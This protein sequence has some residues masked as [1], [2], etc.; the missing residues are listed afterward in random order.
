MERERGEGRGRDHRQWRVAGGHAILRSDAETL[1]RP[2]RTRASSNTPPVAL[3]QSVLYNVHW[4][5]PVKPQR[6]RNGGRRVFSMG[7]KE[8][9]KRTTSS[10]STPSSCPVFPSPRWSIHTH[11]RTRTH[12]R[13][14]TNVAMS[15]TE[16]PRAEKGARAVAV[17]QG[18]Y[19]ARRLFALGK[20]QTDGLRYEGL[21]KR[22]LSFLPAPDKVRLLP[23]REECEREREW[24]RR[25][26]K[27]KHRQRSC[28]V[29]VIFF[30]LT[31]LL[32]CSPFPCVPSFLSALSS[33]LLSGPPLPPSPPHCLFPPSTPFSRPLAPL[34]AAH[35]CPARPHSTPPNSPLLFSPRSTHAERDAGRGRGAAVDQRRAGGG[36]HAHCRAAQLRARH[37]LSP[38]HGHVHCRAGP[39]QGR[40]GERACPLCRSR[41]QS[42]LCP[43]KR[44]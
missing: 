43:W 7:K 26:R 21:R 6:E 28:H 11:T 1:A 31:P 20:G 35:C 39:G 41:S 38:R 10:S 13:T 2:Q 24:E 3:R 22:L 9:Q 29:S 34:R 4:R 16:F 42:R 32:P 14:H 12:T 30:S 44:L 36:A 15:Y 19:L 40:K 23:Y 37:R 18:L 5:P 25:K 17:G 33:S 8:K 27:E